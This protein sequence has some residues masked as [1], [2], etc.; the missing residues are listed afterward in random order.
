ML[1]KAIT[2]CQLLDSSLL[3]WHVLPDFRIG[4]FL[5]D[6]LQ[7]IF[8]IPGKLIVKLTSVP[9]LLFFMKNLTSLVCV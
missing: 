7:Y 9:F 5:R 1:W 3:P 4:Q 2:K 8:G 6:C